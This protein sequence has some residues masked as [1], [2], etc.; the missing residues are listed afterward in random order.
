MRVRFFQS[1]SVSP[2]VTSKSSGNPSNLFP[3]FPGPIF[4]LRKSQLHS[5]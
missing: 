3:F 4:A 5:H 2:F 1:V